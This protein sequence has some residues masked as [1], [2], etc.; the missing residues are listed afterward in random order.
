MRTEA[1]DAAALAPASAMPAEMMQGASGI[2][3]AM[4]NSHLDAPNQHS[5][6]LLMALLLLIHSSRSYSRQAMT[7][8]K[9]VALLLLLAWA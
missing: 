8:S 4:D 6:Q 7:A 3:D 9:A 5:M 2:N 1:V